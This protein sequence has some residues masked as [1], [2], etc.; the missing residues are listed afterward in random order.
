MGD[1][2][3]ANS[4]MEKLAKYLRLKGSRDGLYF[5]EDDKKILEF[6]MNPDWEGSLRG[7]RVW[8]RLKEEHFLLLPRIHWNDLKLRAQ[9]LLRPKRELRAWIALTGL[10]RSRW[11]DETRP[12][13]PAF[14]ISM[15]YLR[16]YLLNKGEK[17]RLN[18]PFDIEEDT[19]VSIVFYILT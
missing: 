3:R 9:K 5:I 12:E 6:I 17:G 4:P 18:T 19:E 2:R 1:R 8:E 14:N 7:H 11:V 16:H 15:R 13:W 10:K